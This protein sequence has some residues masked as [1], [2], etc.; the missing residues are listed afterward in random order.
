MKLEVLAGVEDADDPDAEVIAV[1]LDIGAPNPDPIVAAG[2][3]DDVNAEHEVLAGVENA[4]EP[5]A[6]VIADLNAKLGAA[7]VA[8]APSVEDEKG[9][10]GD[11]VD[12]DG[13]KLNDRAVEPMSAERARWRVCDAGLP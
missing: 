8:R 2:A 13:T 10:K 3:D 5:N 7:E 1:I 11:D 12:A 6:E 9:E 4:D